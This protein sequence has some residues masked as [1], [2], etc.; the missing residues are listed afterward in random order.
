MSESPKT[1]EDTAAAEESQISGQDEEGGSVNL[2]SLT[3]AELIDYA[4]GQGVALNMKMTKADMLSRIE[5]E[6]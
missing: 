3:K 4:A 2:E 1:S 6:E 5:A